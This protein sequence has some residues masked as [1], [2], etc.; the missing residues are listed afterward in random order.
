MNKEDLIN[1]ISLVLPHLTCAGGNFGVGK[2]TIEAVLMAQARIINAE[3][4]LAGGE[5]LLYGLGKFTIVTSVEHQGRNLRTGELMRVPAGR[6]MR[7]VANK[8]MRDALAA[9]AKAMD[10]GAAPASKT[11]DAS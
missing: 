4:D 5:A 3:L 10:G 6:R 7:F 1:N 9:K 2:A 8:A 11:G